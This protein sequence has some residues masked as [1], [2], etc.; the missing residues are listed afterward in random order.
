MSF[1]RKTGVLIY[2]ILMM[3]AASLLILVAIEKITPDMAMSFMRAVASVQGLQIILYAL[4]GLF[5]VIGAVGAMRLSKTS[6]GESII[7]FQNQDGEVTV[8]LRAIEDYIKK[9]SRDIS[10]IND[11]KAHVRALRQGIEAVCEVSL[12]AGANVPDITERIQMAV[13]NRL[14]SILGL[15]EKI[16]IKM[17]VSRII[18]A[19]KGSEITQGQEEEMR[20]TEIPFR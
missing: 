10:G 19:Q 16:S 8:S 2:L 1:F 9:I 5:M 15:E 12:T 3:G 6:S 11:V 17:H 13:R 14:Q 4:G 7:A 20:P 18:K